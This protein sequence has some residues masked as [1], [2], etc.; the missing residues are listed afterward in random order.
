MDKILG[1]NPRLFL[2][3]LSTV[4]ILDLVT[5]E[6]AEV[7]LSERSYDP[8]PFLKLMLIYN[9]GAAFGIFSELPDIL[10]VPLLV[11]APLIALAVT[12]L[13]SSKVSDRISVVALGMVAGGALGNLFDR[14]FLGKVRDFLHLHLGDLY[15]PAFNLADASITLAIG[16]LLFKSLRKR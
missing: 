12:F 2:K 7:F 16:Y 10:R 3:T 9:R 14:I 4:F 6:L 8:L 1:E 15:W 13:Y 5:K 11:G